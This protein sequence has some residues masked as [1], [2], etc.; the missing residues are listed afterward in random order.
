MKKLQALT[1]VACMS[2]LLATGVWAE[3]VPNE[4][5]QGTAEE[6]IP[7]PRCSGPQSQDGESMDMKAMKPEPTQ[8]RMKKS[9]KDM[10]E[11]NAKKALKKKHQNESGAKSGAGDAVSR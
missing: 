2:V 11:Q 3:N 6:G 4:S 7:G 9:N 1:G 10:S 5:S 8:K